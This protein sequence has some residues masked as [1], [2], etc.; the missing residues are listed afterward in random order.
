[1]IISPYKIFNEN[2]ISNISNRE[3]QIQQ[4][5][6]DLTIKSISKLNNFTWYNILTKNERKHID[7]FD[8]KFNKE[9]TILLQIGIYDILFNEEINIPNEMCA[10]IYTRST[11]NRGW[12]FIT[13]WLYDAWYKGM[14]GW[15]LHINIPLLLEKDSRIAQIVFNKAEKGG[16]YEGIY[17]NTTTA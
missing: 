13:A 5:G 1:M 16:L 3:E 10:T 17:N 11:L 8:M 14:L 6:I 4:N 7:R 9:N 2:I 15:I 12:N